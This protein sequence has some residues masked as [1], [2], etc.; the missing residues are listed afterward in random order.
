MSLFFARYPWQDRIPGQ[1]WAKF[2]SV[3]QYYLGA[4]IT[5]VNACSESLQ[6]PGRQEVLRELGLSWCGNE[7]PGS[8]GKRQGLSQAG[9]LER[10]Q[11]TDE[12]DDEQAFKELLNIVFE[13]F[14]AMPL[15]SGSAFPTTISSA[16]ATSFVLESDT[17][18]AIATIAPD[19]IESQAA[20]ASGTI[21]TDNGSAATT[22]VPVVS[23]TTTPTPSP[24]TPNPQI[25]PDSGKPGGNA[26]ANSPQN[27][28]DG[29]GTD[30]NP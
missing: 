28:A 27:P 20:P 16:I 30:T 11:N 8:L 21:I 7:V 19:D 24:A 3:E 26:P 22:M 29:S 14:K 17:A 6:G 9:V 23:P 18:T 1:P 10:R 13:C 4:P 2:V 15:L 5:V 25:A 12:E